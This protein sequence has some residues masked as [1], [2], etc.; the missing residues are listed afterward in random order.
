M[1]CRSQNIGQN[2]SLLIANESFEN[3]ANFKCLG[4]TVTNH[5]DIHVEIKSK[6][7]AWNACCHSVQSLVFPL[8]FLKI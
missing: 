8:S 6:L 7:Y 2:H 4:T 1:V 3:V 5:N